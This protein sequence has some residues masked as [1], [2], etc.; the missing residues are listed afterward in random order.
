MPNNYQYFYTKEGGLVSINTIEDYATLPQMTPELLLFNNK[1]IRE[2]REKKLTCIPGDVVYSEYNASGA[3]YILFCYIMHFYSMRLHS[4]AF[5]E[6]KISEKEVNYYLHVCEMLLPSLLYKAKYSNQNHL[7]QNMP[8]EPYTY[9][10][11]YDKLPEMIRIIFTLITVKVCALYVGMSRCFVYMENKL[12]L[13]K[14]EG[15]IFQNAFDDSARILDERFQT[16]IK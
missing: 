7:P 2:L 3:M 16:L 13:E 5:V 12:Q 11:E 1:Y 15:L 8:S 4:M 9:M 6:K 14:G 10:D